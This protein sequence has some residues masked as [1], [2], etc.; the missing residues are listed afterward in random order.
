MDATLGAQVTISIIASDADGGTF[1]AGIIAGLAAA[2]WALGHHSPFFLLGLIA[3]TLN[4]AALVGVLTAS[5]RPWEGSLLMIVAGL[6]TALPSLLLSFMPL[7]P[8][9]GLWGLASSLCLVWVGWQALKS[10]TWRPVAPA[11]G[12]PSGRPAPG[13]APA[14]TAPGPDRGPAVPHRRRA[15]VLRGVLVAL[16]AV[17]ALYAGLDLLGLTPAVQTLW[18]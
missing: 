18:P 15:K 6:M 8:A 14:R 12:S 4:G 13:P 3:A 9:L 10:H 1:Q 17:T 11:K 16:A 2:L 7:S 5:G